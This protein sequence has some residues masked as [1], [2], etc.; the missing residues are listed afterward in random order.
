MRIQASGLQ[1][2]QEAAEA[3]LVTEFISKLFL[4]Y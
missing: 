1:A 3:T 4:L 2:L